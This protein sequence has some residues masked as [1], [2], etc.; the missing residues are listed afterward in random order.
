MERLRRDRREEEVSPVAIPEAHTMPESTPGL[1]P[2]AAV[3]VIWGPVTETMALEGMTVGEACVLLRGPLN[4]APQVTALVDGRTV[5]AGHR[6]AA[7]ETLEFQ[8]AFGEKG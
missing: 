1:P 8:R 5:R 6:L 4:I 2:R 3:Q 7:G